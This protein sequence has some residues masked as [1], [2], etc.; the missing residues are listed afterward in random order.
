MGTDSTLS[1]G[2]LTITRGGSVPTLRWLAAFRRSHSVRVMSVRDL[3]MPTATPAPD[4]LAGELAAR[5][6]LDAACAAGDV[7]PAP[8]AHPVCIQQAAEREFTGIAGT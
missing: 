7:T 3:S 4:A 5:P 2:V 1:A 8:V 6:P